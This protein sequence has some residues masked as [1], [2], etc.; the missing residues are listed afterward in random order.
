MLATP[1]EDYSRDVLFAAALM[2]KVNF[3]HWAE[4]N[5]GE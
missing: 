5:K 4:Y 1:D 2:A 3:E